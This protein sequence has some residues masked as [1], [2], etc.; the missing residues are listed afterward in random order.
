MFI[1]G[2][3]AHR[4]VTESGIES[5]ISPYLT[6]SG[7]YSIGGIHCESIRSYLSTWIITSGGHLWPFCSDHH[8]LKCLSFHE[9]LVWFKWHDVAVLLTVACLTAEAMH[10]GSL[11]AAQ[12]YFFPISDHVLSLK[13]DSAFYRFQVSVSV[14]WQNRGYTLY[15]VFWLD[16]QMNEFC[17]SL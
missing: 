10:I 2:S 1:V 17:V 6:T 4:L 7:L 13:D 8:I 3:V 9:C 12:G 5:S 11:I 16:M 15:H 14:N